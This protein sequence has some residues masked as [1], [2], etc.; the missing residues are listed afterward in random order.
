M[1]QIAPILL[2]IWKQQGLTSDEI[3]ARAESLGFTLPDDLES[4]ESPAIITKSSRVKG[5]IKNYPMRAFKPTTR[6]DA[7]LSNIKKGEISLF[8][9]KAIQFYTES[10]NQNGN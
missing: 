2:R 1:K 5:S 10:K 6:T 3:I 7:I 9:N 8:I 4:A